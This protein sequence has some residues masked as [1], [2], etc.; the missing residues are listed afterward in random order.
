VRRRRRRRLG[1]LD[2]HVVTVGWAISDEHARADADETTDKYADAPDESRLSVQ[3]QRPEEVL[4]PYAAVERHQLAGVAAPNAPVRAQHVLS[5]GEF[6]AMT[7]SR[8]M[9][10]SAACLFALAVG[11]ALLAWYSASHPDY[12]RDEAPL[13]IF[14]AMLFSALALVAAVS[15]TVLLLIRRF[16]RNEQK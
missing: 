9:V 13:H 2:A 11:A 5:T 15:A 10:L 1:L 14:R 4:H 3:R 16:R 12:A 7:R 6:V 8:V